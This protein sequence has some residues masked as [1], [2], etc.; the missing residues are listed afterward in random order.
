MA[1]N[2]RPEASIYTQLSHPQY[3][4]LEDQLRNWAERETAHTSTEGFY[5]KSIS[6]V[7]AGVRWEFHGPIV[8]AQE[9]MGDT[10]LYGEAVRLYEDNISSQDYLERAGKLIARAARAMGAT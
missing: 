2:D 5:H 4:S 9:P 3:K 10:D 7:V 6:F 8:K 1:D